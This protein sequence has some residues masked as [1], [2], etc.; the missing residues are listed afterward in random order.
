VLAGGEVLD[1]LEDLD[2][3][4]VLREVVDR[5]VLLRVGE[6]VE[7]VRAVQADEDEDPETR[8]DE[9]GAA[10]AGE[11]EEAGD[12]GVLAGLREPVEGRGH[13]GNSSSAHS[14]PIS[15]RR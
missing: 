8:D 11:F 2:R 5:A 6:L 13:T 4:G 3:L 9:A 14:G 7:D 12:P 15:S 1:L 10:A